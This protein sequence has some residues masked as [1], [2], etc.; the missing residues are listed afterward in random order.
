MVM[1]WKPVVFI[2]LLKVERQGMG[3]GEC[4][5]SVRRVQGREKTGA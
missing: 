3:R 1:W 5:D 2:V 4:K